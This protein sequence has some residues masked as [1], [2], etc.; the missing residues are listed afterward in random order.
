MT[1]EQIWESARYNEFFW[2][3]HAA[4]LGGAAMLGLAAFLIR[5]KME[6]WASYAALAFLILL[7]VTDLTV[8]SIQ[9]KWQTRWNAAKTEEQ[10]QRVAD[11]DGANL[12]FAPVIGGFKAMLYCG[13]AVVAILV[14]RLWKGLGRRPEPVDEPWCLPSKRGP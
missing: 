4:G 3:S 7:P 2:L 8:R 12:A 1:F 13:A 9:V 11:G 14:A 10:Q 5:N 6:R